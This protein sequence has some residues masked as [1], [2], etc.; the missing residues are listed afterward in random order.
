MAVRD[1][2]A[3]VSS[4]RGWI[5]VTQGREEGWQTGGSMDAVVARK[6]ETPLSFR[7]ARRA[8]WSVENVRRF[9]G[10]DRRSF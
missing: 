3:H 2:R 8:S 6:N 10:L 9:L 7:T 1:F 4:F 5:D